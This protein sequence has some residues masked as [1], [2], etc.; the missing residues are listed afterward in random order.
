MTETDATADHGPSRLYIHEFIEITGLHRSD[1]VHHMTANWS[2]TAQEE[3]DQRCF[4]VWPVIGSTGRWPEVVNMWELD[5]WAGLAH[6][7]ALEAGGRGA[8]DPRLERWWAHA[9]EFRRGGTDRIVVPAPWNRSIDQLC[10]DG[11]SGICYAH[12]LVGVRPGSS[13]EL[14]ERVH[15]DGEREVTAFGWEPVGAFRTALTNDDECILVWAIP[16][17]E[18][19]AAFEAAADSDSA[20]RSW[21]RSLDDIVT[22]WQR[23]LMVDAPLSPMRIGRQPH[24]DDRTDWTDEA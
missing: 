23:I 20:I 24:R 4:G 9:A 18:A 21:R 11:V 3:R 1:Y 15:Q 22:G 10:A 16:S 5:G 19:W 14:L 2:P 7:F 12:E 17:W 13:H 8:Y 6:G